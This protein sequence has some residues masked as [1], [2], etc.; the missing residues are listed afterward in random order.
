MTGYWLERDHTADCA[1]EVVGSDLETLFI[2][3]AQGLFE[4]AFESRD[5][6]IIQQFCVEIS[7][8]DVETLL[9]DWLNELLYLSDKHN[10]YISG[11]Y[12]LHLVSTHLSA[13][14]LATRLGSTKQYIK[15][16]TFHNIDVLETED[17]FKTEIVFDM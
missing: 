9:I 12:I 7:A 3:A 4:L 14:V 16:A 13:H 17:G 6:V 5:P 2:T 10:V 15:A 8:P 1:I 11:F